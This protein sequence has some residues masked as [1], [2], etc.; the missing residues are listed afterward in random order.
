MRRRLEQ[1]HGR[2]I[3]DCNGEMPLYFVKNDPT[4][5]PKRTALNFHKTA[6]LIWKMAGGADVEVDDDKEEDSN[7]IGEL[8]GEKLRRIQAWREE[9]G[10][11]GELSEDD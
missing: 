1:C 3:L 8:V 6:C 11:A 7:G 2:Q 4:L 9:A 10:S 5:A